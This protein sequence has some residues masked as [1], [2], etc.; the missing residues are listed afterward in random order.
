MPLIEYNSFE[1]NSSDEQILEVHLEYPDEWH[2]LN[3]D[4]RS[5]LEKLKICNNILANYC[6]SIANKCHI[7]IGGVN[8]L[9][10]NLGHKNKYF[11]HYKNLQLHL[12]LRIKLV[13][14]NR[15]LKF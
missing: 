5:V 9:V 3:N 12:L 4:Y 6:S 10:L 8:K 7:K 11:L 1:E 15:I 2:E 13:N 14:V